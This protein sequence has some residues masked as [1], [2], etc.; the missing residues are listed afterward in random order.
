[1]AN[2]DPTSLQMTFGWPAARDAGITGF[3]APP[4][5]QKM[6]WHKQSAEATKKIA[7]L[8]RADPSVTDLA[9]RLFEDL[10][11]RNMHG[12]PQVLEEIY[13]HRPELA[14]PGYW[15][16]VPYIYLPETLKKVRQPHGS[17]QS[18]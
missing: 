17:P 1:M 13:W 6:N 18:K 11:R 9:V 7:A 14:P 12:A 4:N 16:D 15:D 10:T 2:D 5:S 8:T 3:E